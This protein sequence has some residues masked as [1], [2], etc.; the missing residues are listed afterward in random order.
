MH[1]CIEPTSLAEHVLRL[2]C[3]VQMQ[4]MVLHHLL[5]GCT[6]TNRRALDSMPRHVGNTSQ[7]AAR[8]T[9]PFNDSQVVKTLLGFA[10]ISHK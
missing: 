1:R 8:D 10:H 4:G 5:T 2:C 7:H 9:A 6:T 3:A